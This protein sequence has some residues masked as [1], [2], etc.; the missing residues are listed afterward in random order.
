[1][2]AFDRL[3]QALHHQVDG[4][5]RLDLGQ[6]HALERGQDNSGSP[7]RRSGKGRRRTTKLECLDCRRVIRVVLH[8]W[9]IGA[10]GCSVGSS[11]TRPMPPG[12]APPPRLTPGLVAAGTRP[13]GAT[14]RYQPAS[15]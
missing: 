11:A 4:F 3:V 7:V 13:S 9:V 15:T 6:Q 12:T 10:T 1:M 14:R 2:S 5:F 8:T